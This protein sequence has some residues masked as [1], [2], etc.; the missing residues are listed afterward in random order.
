MGCPTNAKRG[1]ALTYLPDAAEKGARVYADCR[2]VRFLFDTRR[3]R[4]IAVEADV[5][6]PATDRPTD[7]RVTVSAARFVLA[8]GAINSPAL[9]LRS[10]APDP[11]GRVGKRTFLHP[12]VATVAL[13][14]RRIDP[15]YGAPQSVASHAFADRPGRSDSSSR[16]RRSTRC[17]RLSPCLASARRTATG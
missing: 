9:L 8:G 11:H 12:V 3:E 1:M 4:V 13:F 5:L 14:D 7:R 16:S 17:S 15:F 2:A 6:D 10:G